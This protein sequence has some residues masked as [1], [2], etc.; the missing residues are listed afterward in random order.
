MYY[1]VNG[2][3]VEEYKEIPAKNDPDVPHD[4]DE[5]VF[6]LWLLMI[7]VVVIIACGLWLLFC[8]RRKEKGQDFGFQFY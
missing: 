2:Q 3:I 5:P 1:R 4:P 7:I 6:P 8:L